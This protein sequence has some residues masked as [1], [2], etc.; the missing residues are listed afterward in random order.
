MTAV[1][2][3]G[4]LCVED[5]SGGGEVGEGEGGGREG[6]GARGGGGGSETL[7]EYI[8]WVKIVMG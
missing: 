2:H 6:E 3:G 1:G 8:M 5:G 4:E 7:H